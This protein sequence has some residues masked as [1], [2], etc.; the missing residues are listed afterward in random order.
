MYDYV[1]HI[2]GIEWDMF[3]RVS[4][5]G[6]RAACQDDPVTFQIMRRSQ[7]EAWEPEV[8]A[9]Y[10]EDLIEAQSQG[11]NLVFEKYA[12]MAEHT[13]PQ[14]YAEIKAFLPYLS[15]EKKLAAENLNARMLQQTD[16][17][18]ARYPHVLDRGRPTRQQGSTAAGGVSIEVYQ[19]GEYLTYSEK[20]LAA[21]A[22]QCGRWDET[23]R[24]LV[25][26]M[27]LN[28]AKRYG[29]VSLEQAEERFAAAA[30]GRDAGG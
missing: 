22:R 19:L 11:R 8:L 13:D 30:R 14:L 1:G 26:A 21:L 9:S 24:S 15:P 20:T 23:G 2:I 28:T 4:D 7:F 12:H 18:A 5:I 10:W 6:G 3:Q 29:F 16:E 25:A 27:L 17:C